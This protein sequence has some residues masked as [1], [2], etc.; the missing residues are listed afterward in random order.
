MNK[1][2]Y[3]ITKKIIIIQLTA[4]I[5]GMLGLLF[6][7]C[8]PSSKL[9]TKSAV[10]IFQTEGPGPILYKEHLSTRLDNYTDSIMINTACYDGNESLVNKAMLNYHYETYG[11]SPFYSFINDTP[12][13]CK[14]SVSYA[15]YWHGYLLVLKPLLCIFEY[16]SLRRINFFLQITLFACIALMMYFRKLKQYILPILGMYIVLSPITI[17]KSLQYSTMFYI[18]T[19]TIIYLLYKNYSFKDK[20]YL[21]YFML[22]VGCITSYFDFLTYPIV[23]LCVSLVFLGLNSNNSEI[24]G[25]EAVESIIIGSASW[26]I[27]Y[28]GM[29]AGKWIFASLL[30]DNNVI[31]DAILSAIYRLSRETSD[32]GIYEKINT[33]LC[34]KNNITILVSPLYLLIGVSWTVFISIISKFTFSRCTNENTIKIR[35]IYF[36]LIGF[37]P[38]LWIIL[39]CNHSFVHSW[40]T[41]RN[42]SSSVLAWECALVELTN[43]YRI[44]QANSIDSSL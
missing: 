12:T 43:Y 7:Y 3:G 17:G 28:I 38:L 34:L 13:L 39:M 11:E 30:T 20:D 26:A 32:S 36:L 21:F 14:R 33:L 23:S 16:S 44:K 18:T 8:I 29:W 37:I 24:T 22:I 41:Y 35:I 15:R 27:G 4:W 42:L 6:V 40:M 2:L 1:K 25:K 5:I 19:F 10:N 9:K 31:K